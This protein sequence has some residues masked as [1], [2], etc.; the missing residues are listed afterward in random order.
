MDENKIAKINYD[1]C[2]NCGQCVYNCPFGAIT[3]RSFIYQV[4]NKLTRKEKPMYALIAP[5]IASQFDAGSIEQISHS[6][7]EL[8]FKDVI[9]VALGADIVV[10]EETLEFQEKIKS[11]DYFTTSCCPAFV[12]LV[13]KHHKESLPNM[14]TTVS[15]MVALGRLVKKLDKDAITVFIGPCIAKKEE[16]MRIE[17]KDAIDYVITFE[18][19]R[20]L[21][22][23][24][25]IDV[26]KME[27]RPLDNASYYGRMFAVSGGVSTSIE[28]YISDQNLDVDFNPVCSNGAHE[29]IKNLKLA[30]FGKL[31]NNFIEGMACVGGCIA[32][33]GSV[34]H[35]KKDI[36][37]I[38]K[39]AASAKEKSTEEALSVI[40]ISEISFHNH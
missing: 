12:Q 39:Y 19:L 36:G 27:K 2:I 10:K 28:E 23:A 8:G 3:D 22:G 6:L 11:L 14:S 18:E 26:T 37:T 31:P 38:K 24:K 20:S 30:K 16:A 32:G 34:T 21:F 15:P 29:C 33:P 4:A 13:R 35:R 40:D 17:V 9:E 7:K 1:K 5:S 25:D